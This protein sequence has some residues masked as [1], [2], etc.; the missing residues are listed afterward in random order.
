MLHVAIRMLKGSNAEIYFQSKCNKRDHY[1]GKET[2]NNLRSTDIRLLS[3]SK[4]INSAAKNIETVQSV[5]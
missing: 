2:L 4:K 1:K 3:L 5:T